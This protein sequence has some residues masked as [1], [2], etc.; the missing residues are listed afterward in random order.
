MRKQRSKQTPSNG[1]EPLT[2]LAQRA[3]GTEA[4]YPL[5][6]AGCLGLVLSDLGEG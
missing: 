1:F 3:P 6:Y 4:L 5:S 2:P